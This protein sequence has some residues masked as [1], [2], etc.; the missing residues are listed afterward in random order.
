MSIRTDFF[1]APKK[2]E[3]FQPP[4]YYV[5]QT[6]EKK[7]ISKNSISKHQIRVECILCFTL[8]A[9]AYRYIECVRV[10]NAC[11]MCLHVYV[12]IDWNLYMCDACCWHVWA[13][14]C[15]Y[16]H[17]RRANF[18]NGQN[19]M[20]WYVMRRP[21]SQ[22]TVDLTTTL[23]QTPKLCWHNFSHRTVCVSRL[24]PFHVERTS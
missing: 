18:S 20:I 17:I 15:V 2:H 14:E 19:Q 8:S 1:G 10:Y 6:E 12:F 5:L 11:A 9:V 13:W 24:Q 16:C 22:T 3:W 7:T 4:P 21:L 23:N